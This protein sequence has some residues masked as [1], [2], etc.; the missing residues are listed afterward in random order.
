MNVT[1]EMSSG[2]CL[3]RTNM[4][5][6]PIIKTALRL[7]RAF[8]RLP[9]GDILVK[10]PLDE[11]PELGLQTETWDPSLEQIEVASWFSRRPTT[12]WNAKELKAWKEITKTFEFSGD[13]WDALRWYYKE[14]GCDYIRKDLGTL[15]NNWS[16][17]IDRAKQ[18]DP[19]KK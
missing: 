8:E 17:E 14:S 3:K 2:G 13:D 12:V 18:Y 5:I 1:R 19:S 15:L 9:N 10:A 7:N 16:G 4:K 6:D 11:T